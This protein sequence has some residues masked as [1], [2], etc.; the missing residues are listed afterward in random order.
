MA[1]VCEQGEACGCY[2][3]GAAAAHT[4]IRALARDLNHPPLCACPV[5]VTFR[6]VAM[7]L[8]ERM[9]QRGWEVRRTDD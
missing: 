9:K 1:K 5:C 7:F 2:Q 8:D 4:E 6:A 3:A